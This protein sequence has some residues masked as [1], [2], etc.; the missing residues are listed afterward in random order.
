MYDKDAPEQ[1][2]TEREEAERLN[3]SGKQKGEELDQP[4]AP[5]KKD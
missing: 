2:A 3:Q 5:G 1:S 4:P